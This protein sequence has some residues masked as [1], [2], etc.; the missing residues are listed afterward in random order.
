MLSMV[1]ATLN[2]SKEGNKSWLEEPCI[3]VIDDTLQQQLA[4]I[5]VG[6]KTEEFD[7]MAKGSVLIFFLNRCKFQ[8]KKVWL[9]WNWGHQV[10]CA[11][12]WCRV[13]WWCWWGSI[14]GADKETHLYNIGYGKREGMEKLMGTGEK[15]EMV[16]ANKWNVK[17]RNQWY[18]VLFV[19]LSWRWRT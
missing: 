3:D 7:N 19:Y 5:T 12:M 18:W 11:E 9:T 10:R 17:D 8:I 1:V 6:T 13:T 14:K 16:A 2:T 15:W 4:A